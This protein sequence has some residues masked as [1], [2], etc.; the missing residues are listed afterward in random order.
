[1]QAE[2]DQA[3]MESMNRPAAAA[4]VM[5]APTD[6]KDKSAL[7]AAI[8]S[9]QAQLSNKVD[10]ASFKKLQELVNTKA[11]NDELSRVEASLNQLRGTSATKK[12]VSDELKHLKNL[13][14]QVSRSVLSVCHSDYFSLCV[15]C[16]SVVDECGNSGGAAV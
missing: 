15:L 16:L 9:F 5:M 12:Y 13:E 11:R 4:P 2:L 6:E 10:S 14:P 8:S 1:M 7:T 3:K